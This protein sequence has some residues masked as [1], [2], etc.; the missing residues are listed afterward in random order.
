M[1]GSSSAH[2]GLPIARFEDVLEDFRMGRPVVVL[3]DES[4]EN[5]GDVVLATEAVTPEAVAFLMSEARGLI[6][7]SV[8]AET[9]NRLNLPLQVTTNNSPHQT[10]FAVSV[11]HRD[12]AGRGVTASARAHTMRMMVEPSSTASDFIIPGHVFPLIAN[13]AGVL[14]RQGHTEGSFDLAR[15]A[16]L[17]PSGILCEVLNPDGTMARGDQIVDFCANHSL[18]ITTIAEIRHYRML[19]EIAVRQLS[20]K[21]VPTDFGPFRATVFADDVGGREHLALVRG[22]LTAIPASYAPLVRLHS[23]C[24]TGDVFG[25]RRCDCGNQLAGAME[26]VVEEGVGIVLYL[27]QEGRGIGLENK[28]RA[29]ELQDQG[30]DTVEANLRLGFRADE[31]DFAVGAHML[32]ALGVRQIRLMTNNPEKGAVLERYGISIVEQVPM[33]TPEDPCSAGYLRTK[34]EKLG[35]L[36]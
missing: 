28:L 8:S 29:Y 9:A 5:E 24:L 31:R 2:Q 13:D 17:T 19:N 30:L 11:D 35:H 20:T 15:L 7:V 6:C 4:R 3:D 36:L 16:G 12:V 33:L 22:D 1:N 34:R 25:S 23:E 26:R 27:R 32:L 18:K 14:K 21:D 10:P